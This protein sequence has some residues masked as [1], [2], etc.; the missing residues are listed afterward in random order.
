MKFEKEPTCRAALGLMDSH[1]I[2]SVLG[3]SCT[4][5]KVV[6]EGSLLTIK[7]EKPAL[8]Q[9]MARLWAQDRGLLGG[10]CSAFRFLLLV[11]SMWFWMST[12]LGYVRWMCV[13]S[14]FVT[15]S[16]TGT[17]QEDGDRLLVD[18]LR[19]CG[20]H[21]TRML[22]FADADML[23]QDWYTKSVLPHALAMPS[24]SKQCVL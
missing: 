8:A 9:S 24:W 17:V 6:E 7:L 3:E 2:T 10:G 18:I 1:Q 20:C 19:W 14:K 4:S 23:K 13:D 5:L 16:S 11:G 21:K 22:C 15:K 12:P